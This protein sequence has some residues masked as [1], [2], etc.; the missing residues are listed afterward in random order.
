[1]ETVRGRR[2]TAMPWQVEAEPKLVYDL[3]AKS[4]RLV[5][6][7][8][9]R[10]PFGKIIAD[11][12]Q[13]DAVCEW[14]AEGMT[15][16]AVGSLNLGKTRTAQSLASAFLGADSHLEASG[17]EILGPLVLVSTVEDD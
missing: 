8:V 9:R 16:Q 11:I 5:T 2:K 14:T 13:K 1:M 7:F 4:T 12:V 17:W 15:A 10:D 3:R 6:R